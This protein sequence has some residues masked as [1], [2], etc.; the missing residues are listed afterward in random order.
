MSAQTDAS[1]SSR[2]RTV[3]SLR[4]RVSPSIMFSL[5]LTCQ[6][7]LDCRTNLVYLVFRLLVPTRSTTTSGKK[8]KMWP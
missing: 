1:I 3:S 4:S 2:T 6:L 8:M 5:V 7:V